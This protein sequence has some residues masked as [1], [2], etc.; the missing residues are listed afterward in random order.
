MIIIGSDLIAYEPVFL[1]KFDPKNLNP[2]C[3]FI[4]V[5]NIK[6]ALIANANGVKFIVCDTIKLAKKL[7]KLANNYLFDSKIALIINSDNEL[8]KAAKKQIDAVIYLGA[9]RG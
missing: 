1:S 5:S 6:E 4:V 8:E 3:N 2:K 7:Q 9:I